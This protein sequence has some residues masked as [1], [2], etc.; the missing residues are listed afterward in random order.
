LGVLFFVVLI[1]GVF[2]GVTGGLFW[3]LRSQNRSLANDIQTVESLRWSWV[4]WVQ[5][6]KGSAKGLIIGLITGLT[7]SVLFVM[8]S[9]VFLDVFDLLRGHEIDYEALREG[10]SGVL[11][12]ESIFGLFGGVIGGFFGGLRSGILDIKAIPNLGIKLSM[13]NAVFVGLGLLILGLGVGLISGLTRG[14]SYLRP[15]LISVLPLGLLLF[16]WYGGQDVIQHY[17]LRFIFYW[18]GHT[19]LH[20]AN[21]LD[22]AAL[23][24]FLQKVGGGYIFIHRLLLE[25]FAAMRIDEKKTH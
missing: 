20:Y 3:G 10:L 16:F 18:K 1:L 11:L 7:V 19:P 12:I 14:L 6:R 25:H 22:Y 2:F 4:H 21:F 9:G 5:A 23:L 13:R 8:I 15:G 24:V 17:I